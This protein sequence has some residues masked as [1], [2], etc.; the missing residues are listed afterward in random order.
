MS[1]SAHKTPVAQLLV[2]WRSGRRY[3]APN[4]GS[5]TSYNISDL[6][7]SLGKSSATDVS[8]VR[9]EE[10]IQ[11]MN[12]VMGFFAKK[13]GIW[14]LACPSDGK[15]EENPPRVTRYG[16]GPKEVE[17]WISAEPPSAKANT[18]PKSTSK[19]DSFKPETQVN[20]Y[21]TV[22]DSFTAKYPKVDLNANFSVVNVGSNL[23]LSYLPVEIRTIKPDQVVK[24][25]LIGYQARLMLDLANRRPTSNAMFIV[26]SGK[27]VGNSLTIVEDRVLPLSAI[28]YKNRQLRPIKTIP[29]DGSWNIRDTRFHTFGD[30]GLWTSMVIESDKRGARWVHGVAASTVE[31]FRIHLDGVGI[32]IKD[33]MGRPAPVPKHLDDKEAATS[34][35]IKNVFR[36]ISTSAKLKKLWFLLCIFPVDDVMLYNTTKRFGDIKAGIHTVCVQYSKFTKGDPQYF[37]NVALKFNPKAGGINQTIN[38]LGIINEGKTMAV[39]IDVTHPSPELKEIAL[40]VAT[41]VTST[42]KLLGQWSGICR[43][44]GAARQEPVSKL[45]SMFT[46]QLDIW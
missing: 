5:A 43:L 40:S 38:K 20:K 28:N 41:M 6:V 24:K 45:E 35:A 32:G 9:R 18:P 22:Y 37:G 8:E 17:F 21:V 12:T 11:A 4:T 29:R 10:A 34:A 15:T 27:Q 2:L 13:K 3:L 14:E 23:K 31:Q 26:T 19:K 44:Q 7:Q 33:Y 16:A 42:D 25:A 46:R 1:S 30:L 39:G 36:T